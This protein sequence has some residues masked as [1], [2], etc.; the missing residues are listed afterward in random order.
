VEIGWQVYRCVLGQ[1]TKWDC[2]YLWVVRLV[3]PVAA[4]LEDRRGYFTVSWSR[5]F[6]K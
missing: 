6:D 3:V 1:G 2:L 5:Y 4:W